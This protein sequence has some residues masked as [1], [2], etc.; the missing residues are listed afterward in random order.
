MPA[1]VSNDFSGEFS[2][3]F[4]PPLQPVDVVDALSVQDFDQHYRRPRRPVVINDGAQSWRALQ[5]WSDPAYLVA[6]AG[7][8][9]TFVR[10]L[11][12]CNVDGE[13]YH[14]AYR[15]V[16]F[17][18]LV[19]RLFSDQPPAWYLT[20]GLVMRGNGLGAMMARR[21]WPA[22]LPELASDLTPPPYW[23]LDALAQCNLWMGPG[24]QCSGMHYDEFD[25]LN[26]VV[27]GSK[28]WLL[29]PHDQAAVLLNGSQVRQTIAPGF[30]AGEANRFAGARARARGYECVIRP[31]Q[32]LY[33]PAGMWHQ[34]F[35]GP[36]PG[37]A[38]NY[39]YL[40][41]PRDAVRAAVLHARR[42]S[43]FSRR[44]RFLLALGVIGVQA[45]IKT[46]QYGFGRR[47]PAEV[48]IGPPGYGL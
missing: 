20:Q 26:G 48:E 42:F 31:G 28:R 8:R 23:P 7:H 29:F 34:V 16:A 19:E 15:E 3:L 36:G 27:L 10:D 13:S 40:S 33:V 21:T 45:A 14:E 2:P 39:W 35:S 22:S 18:E 37:L 38:V 17:G 32:L 11:D 5:R 4:D 41:L 30:H 9:N 1:P 6:A 24:N 25:N 44:K 12:A 43:G 47:A 46:I